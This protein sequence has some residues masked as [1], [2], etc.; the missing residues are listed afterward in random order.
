MEWIIGEVLVSFLGFYLFFYF[1][2]ERP[3]KL[4]GNR[5]LKKLMKAVDEVIRKENKRL[6]TNIFLP[7]GLVVALM[8]WRINPKRPGEYFCS[9][10]CSFFRVSHAISW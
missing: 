9:I 8:D 4:A 5:L 10:C 7:V 6:E 2:S 3:K 1:C